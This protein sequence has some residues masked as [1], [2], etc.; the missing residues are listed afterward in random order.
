M[1]KTEPAARRV[2]LYARVSTN[3]H[4]AHD[5]QDPETQLHEMRRHC[6]YKGWTITGEYVDRG[7]SGAKTSRPELNC[8]MKDASAKKFNVV[9]IWRFDRFGRSTSH[10]LASLETFKALGIEFASLKEEVDTLTAHGKMVFTMLA[11]VAEMERA[12]TG[13]RIKAKLRYIRESEGRVPGPKRSVTV[14]NEEVK[15][16]VAA[17]ESLREIARSL[18]CSGMLLSARLK[19]GR[20]EM[21]KGKPA[22]A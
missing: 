11:A 21:K 22:V 2:A 16:R 9:L 15:R 5:G 14:T 3:G 4:G 17:G 10:L 18:G 12:L 19:S 8:L 7:W 20:E 13:E 1:T 6:E